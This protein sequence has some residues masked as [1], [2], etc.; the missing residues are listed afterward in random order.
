MQHR[1]WLLQ[2]SLG[3]L[4]LSHSHTAGM[5]LRSK[6]QLGD[7]SAHLPPLKQVSLVLLFKNP[8][9]IQFTQPSPGRAPPEVSV[10][11]PSNVLNR[12]TAPETQ[13]RRANSLAVGSTTVEPQLTQGWLLYMGLERE[14]RGEEAFLQLT[15]LPH[16]AAG[17]QKRLFE[18][19]S[20]MWPESPCTV[21][22][23]IPTG[24]EGLCFTGHFTTR[25]TNLCKTLCLRLTVIR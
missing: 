9:Q 2:L 24:G 3:S 18:Q 22:L 5:G 25:C 7:C 13:L 12:K 17:E 21:S 15:Q 8:I 10:P 19:L 1:N 14:P 16:F 23:P 20:M 6:A 4:P 11:L